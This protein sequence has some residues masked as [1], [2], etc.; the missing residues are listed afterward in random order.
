MPDIVRRMNHDKLAQVL[1]LVSPARAAPL[2]AHLDA[3]NI[4]EVL[5]LVG[6]EEGA[7]LHTLLKREQYY[8]HYYRGSTTT[9]T[10]TTTTDVFYAPFLRQS[11]VVSALVSYFIYF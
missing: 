9:H 6:E 1:A 11:C 8:T 4:K 10:T 7:L 3:D 2:I 5:P